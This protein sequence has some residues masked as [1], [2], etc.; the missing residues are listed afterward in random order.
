M[1]PSYWCKLP[2][3]ALTAGLLLMLIGGMASCALD[4]SAAPSATLPGTE[5]N[6]T[7]KVTPTKPVDRVEWP[8]EPLDDTPAAAQFLSL[9]RAKDDSLRA[10]VRLFNFT[11]TDISELELELQCSDKDGRK[12]PCLKPWRT[13]RQVPA[14]SH[15]SHVI[16]AHLPEELEDISIRIVGARMAD[17]NQWPKKKKGSR[18]GDR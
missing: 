3:R 4:E 15:V 12:I 6:P 14:R 18:G 5:A 9:V 13:T 10:K 1:L 16:G 8:D 11:E 17:G 2:H 7:E